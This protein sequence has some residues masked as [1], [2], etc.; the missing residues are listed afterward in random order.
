MGIPL[1]YHGATRRAF[2]TIEQKS[3]STNW[4]IS[5]WLQMFVYRLMGLIT[6]LIENM[7]YLRQKA[8]LDLQSDVKRVVMNRVSISTAYELPAEVIYELTW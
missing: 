4:W 2:H 6:N 1:S 5:T 8:S 3:D 7:N